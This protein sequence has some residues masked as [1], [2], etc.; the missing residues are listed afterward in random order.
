MR[1]AIVIGMGPGRLGG[2]LRRCAVAIGGRRVVFGCVGLGGVVSSGVMSRHL[3][4]LTR[5]WTRVAD[6]SL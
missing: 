2:S 1:R 4:S 3:M 6:K 5:A